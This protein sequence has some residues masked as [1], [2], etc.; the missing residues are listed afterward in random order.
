MR[1]TKRFIID[2]L[3]HYPELK[4]EWLAIDDD[5]RAER[6]LRLKKPPKDKLKGKS[7]KSKGK[8]KAVP[9]PPVPNGDNFPVLSLEN[10]E[11][12]SESD[13]DE[14][15]GST[16]LDGIAKLDSIENIHFYDVWGIRIFKREV[17]TGR[18]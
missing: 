18:L 12:G 2:T 9:L 11:L 4:L 7:S 6:I 16:G 10:L 3:S 13:D 15:E 8:E 5:E 17:V 1:E 14:E